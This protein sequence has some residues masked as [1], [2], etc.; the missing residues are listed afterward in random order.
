MNRNL[1]YAAVAVAGF[2]AGA[3]LAF[4]SHAQVKTPRQFDYDILSEGLGKRPLLEQ[5]REAGKQ[6]GEAV[7]VIQNAKGPVEVIV[8]YGP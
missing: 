4:P 2:L 7:G 1:T 6:G 5:L 3:I 8:K